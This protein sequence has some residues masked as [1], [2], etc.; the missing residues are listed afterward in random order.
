MAAAKG[1]QAL[2]SLNF[3]QHHSRGIP[4]QVAHHLAM[5][6]ILPTMFWASPAWWTGTLM[7]TATLHTTYNS[8]A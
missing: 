7:I 4:V 1:N 8:V 6:A 3:L 2:S 5:A